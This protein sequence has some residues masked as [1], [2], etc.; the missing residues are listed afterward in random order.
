MSEMKTQATAINLKNLIEITLKKFNLHISYCYGFTSDN[1]SN[2]L[3][4]G[5]I[6]KVDQA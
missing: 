5:I 4:A 2:Y 1:G 3:K 6:L